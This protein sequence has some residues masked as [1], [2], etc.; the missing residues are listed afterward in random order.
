[1]QVLFP[2]HVWWHTECMPTSHWGT[3]A[4]HISLHVI[5]GAWWISS[6][7]I[8]D[9][10]PTS[11]SYCCCYLF[12]SAAVTT[13]A[14]YC[15]YLLL[16]LLA[17][18]VTTAVPCHFCYSLHCCYLLQYFFSHCCREIIF[19]VHAQLLAPLIR[20]LGIVSRQQIVCD[21]IVIILLCCWYFACTH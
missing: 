3:G 9:P 8:T 20:Q 19:P 11:L 6:K 13:V 17:T 7:Q 10:L 1:M 16:L 18:A 21:T 5:S 12:C 15:C 4:S 14:C 2:K